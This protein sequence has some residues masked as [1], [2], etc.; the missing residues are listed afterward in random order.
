MAKTA[1]VLTKLQGYE[2]SFLAK[3]QRC[4]PAKASFLAKA[5]RCDHDENCIGADQTARLR[6]IVPYQG[7]KMRS[8]KKRHRC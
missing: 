6:S 1:T 8:W 3:A 2:A 5:Q 4:D 7:A